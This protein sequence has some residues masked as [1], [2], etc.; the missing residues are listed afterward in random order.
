VFVVGSCS[1][2]PWPPAAR[3]RDRAPR[4]FAGSLRER[5]RL[6]YAEHMA[7]RPKFAWFE[8]R[9]VPFEDA[10]VP[11][12]DRGLQFSESLYEVA[13]ITKGC[14][15]LL[16]EHVE[17]MR[18]SAEELG[19]VAG[20][21]SLPEW[22]HLIA[23]LV[24]HEGT[25]DGLLYAQVTGGATPRLHVP[26]T[27]TEPT[28]FAYVTP[29]AFP[30]DTDVDR[31]IRAVSL[32]DMRWGRCDLKTTM[33]LAAVLAKREA[34]RAGA[35]EAVL[36]SPAGLV[37]EGSSSNVFAVERGVLVTPAQS[38]D[39]LPGTMRPLVCE[40]GREAG[41][42]VRG[43]QLTISRLVTADEIFITSTSQLV[44]PVVALDDRP[45]GNGHGGLVARDL[46][47]R[48]RIRFELE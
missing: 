4:R 19:L 30:R 43:E 46:A 1:G 32:P 40:L 47:R 42:E 41:L 24:K 15:R 12:D 16:P 18:G 5:E 23:E 10:K 9:V 27:P 22:Q 2:E 14:P 38:R 17:R 36:V 8:G 44:M 6:C 35:D 37:H 45:V 7:V 31:G 26:S 29:Y 33:L 21:P 11:L 13:P 34:R 48:L 25:T 28:F 3:S 20:V 39:L